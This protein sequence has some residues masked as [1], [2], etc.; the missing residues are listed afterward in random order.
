M[1]VDQLKPNAIVRGPLFHEPIQIIIP[2]SKGISVKLF[3]KSLTTGHT[4]NSV[5]T[6]EQIATLEVSPNIVPFDRNARKFCLG[7]EA[8]RFAL[9]YEYDSCVAL[10]IARIDPLHYQ[11][12][13]VHKN[14]LAQPRIHFLL[15][16]DPGERQYYQNVD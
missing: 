15:A 4:Y 13:V 8:L 9:T 12:E 1:K 11:L 6:P 14:S 5:L 10:S 3:S 16:D 2:V 7:V